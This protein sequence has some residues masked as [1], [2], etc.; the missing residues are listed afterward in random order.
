MRQGD[1]AGWLAM[2]WSIVVRDAAHG[3]FGIAA[4]SRF[5][6]LGALVPFASRHGALATQALVNPTYGARGLRLLAEGLP[7]GLALDALVTLDEGRRHRQVHVIDAQGRVAAWTG[8]DC[9]PWAGHRSGVD[10]SVAGNMLVG[11]C[12]LEATLAAYAAS[13]GH[14]LAERLLQA[15]A[16]GEA[17]GGD[18]RGRQSAVL[19]IQG[20]QAYPRLS[21]RVDDH[22]EPLSELRRLYRVATERFLSF[23]TAFPETDL[24]PGIIDRSSIDER[25]AKG[26]RPEGM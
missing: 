25:I 7:A 24:D 1:S 14:L 23:S 22:P 15:M 19:H 16:A 4:A 11:E 20:R 9:V 17:A 18:K 12:V 8:D 6:A 21:L 26:V 2:T 3:L 10:V 5:F 13:S